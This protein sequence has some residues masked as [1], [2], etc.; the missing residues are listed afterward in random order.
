M[1]VYLNHQMGAFTPGNRCAY[2]GA[3]ADVIQYKG[4]ASRGSS[5]FGRDTH[6]QEK[7][8]TDFTDH[9]DGEKELHLFFHPRYP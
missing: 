1:E 5:D 8:T 2:P 3:W 9:T 7:T 4:S 6:Q